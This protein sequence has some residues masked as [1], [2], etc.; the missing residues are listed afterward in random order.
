MIADAFL[1]ELYKIAKFQLNTSKYSWD[2]NFDHSK[3]GNIQNPVFL[4]VGFQMVP[5]IPK[6]EKWQI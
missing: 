4:K 1:D 2:L 6:L 5:T 3:S